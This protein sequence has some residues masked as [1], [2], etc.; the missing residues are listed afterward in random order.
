MSF[1]SLPFIFATRTSMPVA[2]ASVLFTMPRKPPRTMTKRQTS[3]ASLKPLT[4]AMVKLPS[5][6]PVTVP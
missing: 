2:R 5:V 4:D 6:A 1:S 3:T